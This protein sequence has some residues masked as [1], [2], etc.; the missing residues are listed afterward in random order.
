MGLLEAAW[1]RGGFGD[2]DQE[3]QLHGKAKA[4]LERY[5]ERWRT[6]DA[7]PVW[8]ER[9]FSFKLGPHLLRGRVD[10]VDELPDGSHELIDYKTGR[11]KT[12]AQLRDDVQLA[13]YALAAR[14]AWDLESSLQ[15]Y[16]YVLD[17]EKVPLPPAEVDREWISET[18]FTVAEGI[19]GQGFE[20]SPSY[21][22]CSICDYRIVCPAAER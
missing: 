11:P 22:A 13:V 18:V 3:R 14:E 1:R 20:P 21:A 15:S 6:E 17:D 10:R 5:L 12:A 7:E 8:F 16:H 19:L 2:T 4:A 9:A